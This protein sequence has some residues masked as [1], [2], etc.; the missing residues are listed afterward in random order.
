MLTKRLC[1]DDVETENIVY[2][3]DREIAIKM[4]V[5]TKKAIHIDLVEETVQETEGD[6]ETEML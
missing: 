1:R 3:I 4:M 6:L 2:E 5:A